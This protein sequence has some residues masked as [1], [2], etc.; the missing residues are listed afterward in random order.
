MGRH[1]TL[2]RVDCTVMLLAGSQTDVLTALRSLRVA[3]R[4]RDRG[5][6]G[7]PHV[8]DKGDGVTFGAKPG[9]SARH[10]SITFYSKAQD[11]KIHRLPEAMADDAELND[12]LDLCLRSEVRLGSG[13]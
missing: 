10:R 1:T 5:Q 2:S 8:W 3:G 11:A 9:K 6:S 7:L 13:I 4:L 12:W